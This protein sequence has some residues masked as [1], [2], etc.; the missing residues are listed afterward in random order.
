MEAM[1]GRRQFWFWCFCFCFAI[2]YVDATCDSE[3]IETETRSCT[4]VSPTTLECK[5]TRED[6]QPDFLKLR[7]PF[8]T[9]II[10]GAMC[11]QLKQQIGVLRYEGMVLEDE[12]CGSIPRCR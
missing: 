7:H 6:C 4:C 10:S 1:E 5:V 3:K 9:I 11:H 12:P 2:F 8:R